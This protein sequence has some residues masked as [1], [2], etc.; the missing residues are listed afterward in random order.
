MTQFVGGDK[1]VIGDRGI[2]LSGGQKA[3]VSLARA[4]YNEGDIVL[5]DSPLAAVDSHVGDHIFNKCIAH[6]GFLSGKTRILVTSQV[7]R[8]NTRR[9]AWVLELI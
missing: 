8:A 3:R 1:V 6:G 9:L 2:N 4:C 7:R 5:L